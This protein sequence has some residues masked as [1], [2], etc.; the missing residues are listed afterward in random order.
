MSAISNVFKH[1]NLELI[2]EKIVELREKIVDAEYDN[3]RIMY[4]RNIEI[5]NGYE[6]WNFNKFKPKRCKILKQ[7]KEAT[8]VN[9]NGLPIKVTPHH[10]FVF[11]KNNKTYVGGIWF[12]AKKEG[13]SK[14]E[15]GMFSDALY[16]SLMI[17]YSEEYSLST[18]YCFAI[19]VVNKFDVN[20]MQMQ[21]NE[22]SFFLDKIILELKAIK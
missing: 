10:V 3:S 20:Y 12:V 5:L 18:E 1:E 8:I 17:N 4:R 22:V 6:N 11:E 9:I 14:M 16:R 2:D 7:H 19:D 13:F 15:L 21:N